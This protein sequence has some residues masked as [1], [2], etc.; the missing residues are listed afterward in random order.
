LAF[1]AVLAFVATFAVVFFAVDA[2]FVTRGFAFAA[3]LRTVAATARFA[4]AFFAVVLALAFA[5][6]A[7]LTVRAAVVL[8]FVAALRTVRVA[9]FL[10]GAFFAV[11]AAAISNL[12]IVEHG[13][14]TRLLI[15]RGAPAASIPS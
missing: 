9:V 10:A 6:V 11:L 5:G 4:G 8:A 3:L 1:V 14:S 12:Q 7:F 13:V 2:A 15:R